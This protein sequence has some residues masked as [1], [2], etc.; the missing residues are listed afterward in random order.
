MAGSYWTAQFRMIYSY[1][2]LIDEATKALCDFG[3]HLPALPPSEQ[4]FDMSELFPHYLALISTRH[5]AHFQL[6]AL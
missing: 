5:I 3:N 1:S 4:P 6:N 2:A